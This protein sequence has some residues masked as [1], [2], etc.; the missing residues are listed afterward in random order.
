MELRKFTDR[1]K[2]NMV[3]HNFM[4]RLIINNVIKRQIARRA[5]PDLSGASGIVETII[6]MATYL[7]EVIGFNITEALKS[8]NVRSQEIP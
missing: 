1:L 5:C 3:V 4:G 7:V 2:C 6:H 8:E